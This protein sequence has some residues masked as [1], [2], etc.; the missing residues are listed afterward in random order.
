MPSEV[1]ERAECPNI[2][3]NEV[4]CTC[5]SEDCERHGF[6]CKCIENHRNRGNFPACV[7]HLL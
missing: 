2:E 7:R 1:R 5:K 4:D 3:I 6:C